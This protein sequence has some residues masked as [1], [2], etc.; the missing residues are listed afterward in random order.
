MVQ[1]HFNN[2]SRNGKIPP[3]V[4]GDSFIEKEKETED[5]N[6][7]W[8]HIRLHKKN[9]GLKNE[10]YGYCKVWNKKIVETKLRNLV[11]SLDC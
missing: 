3:S 8:E 11:D 9:I 4:L 7:F 6:I 5:V 10:M 2:G 1:T